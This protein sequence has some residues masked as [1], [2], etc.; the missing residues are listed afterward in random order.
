MNALSSTKLIA[1]INGSVQAAV[2]C[3]RKKALLKPKNYT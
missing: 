1:V 3:C 2:P